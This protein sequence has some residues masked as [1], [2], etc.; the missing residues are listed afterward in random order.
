[1][2]EEK[3]S[4]TEPSQPPSTPRQR[5]MVYFGCALLISYAVILV[6]VPTAKI[7]FPLRIG[8]AAFNLIAAAALWLA[9]RQS[10]SKS[11]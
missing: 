10:T 9:A 2:P 8:L 4:P 11:K 1:M 7:S 3:P 6:A 5:T